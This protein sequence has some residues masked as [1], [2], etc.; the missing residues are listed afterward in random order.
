M[1]DMC[2]KEEDDQREKEEREK[3]FFKKYKP[4]SKKESREEC[5]ERAHRANSPVVRRVLPPVMFICKIKS[6]EEGGYLRKFG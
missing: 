5:K 3:D 4:E 6:P 2:R 1:Y